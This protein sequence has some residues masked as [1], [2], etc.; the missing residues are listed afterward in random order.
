MVGLFALG[1]ARLG[2]NGGEPAHEV[3]GLLYAEHQA[4]HVVLDAEQ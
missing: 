2:E 4:V 3:E 1:G